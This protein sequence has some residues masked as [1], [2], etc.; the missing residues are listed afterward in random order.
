MEKII[1]ELGFDEIFSETFYSLFILLFCTLLYVYSIEMRFICIEEDK[2][3]NLN[4]IKY[5]YEQNQRSRIKKEPK[6]KLS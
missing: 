2:N 5:L 6:F 3:N 4:K 1:H